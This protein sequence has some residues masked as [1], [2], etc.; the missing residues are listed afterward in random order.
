MPSPR[1][2]I[3]GILT[4]ALLSSCSTGRF[5]SQAAKG[6][7]EILARSRPLSVVKDDPTTPPHIR[8]QL[9]L[10]ERLLE[11]AENEL[12][13]HPGTAY[14]AYADLGRDHV[15]WNIFAAAE[16]SLTPK[17]WRYPIVGK[18]NYRGYFSEEAALSAAQA[19]ED[20]G[21]DTVVGEVDAYS[22]LGWFRDPLLNTFI[23]DNEILLAELIFHELTHRRLFRKGQTAFNEALATAVSY[24]GVRRWLQAEG[25]S[26]QL[27]NYALLLQRRA[28]FYAHVESTRQ[29]LRTLYAS[30][31]TRPE[32]LRRKTELLAALQDDFRALHRRWGSSGS[33]YWLAKPLNNAHLVASATYQQH[34]P[35]FENLLKTHQNNLPN[36]FRAAKKLPKIED[37][38]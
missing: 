19:L 13:L 27:D 10:A 38:D 26:D 3:I 2:L 34:L 15:V 33:N 37:E 1:L 6:Q 32:K 30:P 35:L 17:E 14:S 36:F 25:K 21:Y 18:L 4:L 29:E 16:L 22:T 9:I 28:A 31:G 20:E 11:F 8:S 7:F 12:S 23:E 5:Y 24:E